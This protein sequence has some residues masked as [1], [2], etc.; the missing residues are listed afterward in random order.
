MP[1]LYHGFGPPVFLEVQGPR[2]DHR[3][4]FSHAPCPSS[5][6]PTRKS[7]LGINLSR[8]SLRKCFESLREE[9]Q[10]T[11]IVQ[12]IVTL[13]FSSPKIIRLFLE[14]LQSPRAFQSP[15][16]KTLGKRKCP[17]SGGEQVLA[18]MLQ[19]GEDHSIKPGGL[20]MP[21][22]CSPLLT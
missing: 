16:M 14:I 1:T 19:R 9:K 12:Y 4:V 11:R 20:Y 2:G 10:M 8:R 13:S 6:Q 5:V 3:G 17:D 15:W 22:V 18:P 7:P 21:Q